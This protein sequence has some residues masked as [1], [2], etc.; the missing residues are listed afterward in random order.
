MGKTEE[1]IGL[2]EHRF[3]RNFMPVG[4]CKKK[5]I[6][7]RRLAKRIICAQEM[8]IQATDKSQSVAE[9]KI[10]LP[11]IKG[12]VWLPEKEF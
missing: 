4:K 8:K 1:E 9:G 11:S 3:L 6:N 10:H 2:K 5:G 12:K 7:Q